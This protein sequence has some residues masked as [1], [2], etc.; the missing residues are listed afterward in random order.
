[1]KV[2]TEEVNY[3][4]KIHHNSIIGYKQCL[5]NFAKNFENAANLK[6][7]VPIFLDTNVLLRYYS[8][9]FAAREKLYEFIKENKKRI[10][11]SAQV[12]Y[13]FIKNREEVIQRFFEQ[14]TNKIPRDFKTD[15]VNK[16]NSF[17]DVHKI[18]LQDYPFVE[19]DIAKHQKELDELLQ[20]LNDTV[21]H[22]RKEHVDLILKDKFLNLLSECSLYESLINEEIEIV[23]KDF[24]ILKKNVTP[25]NL[26]SLMNKT[27]ST[28]PGLG[29][30]KLKPDN[31]YGDYIIYHEI[32]KY[33]ITQKTD[34]I[35]L[36]FDTTKG[37]WMTKSKSPHLHYI[38][39]IHANTGQ[40]LY[41]LD[42]DRTLGETLNTN[43]ESLVEFEKSSTL[44][45][46]LTLENI[47]TFVDRHPIFQNRKPAILNNDLLNELYLAGYNSIEEIMIDL[48]LG[49]KILEVYEKDRNVSFNKLG[50]LRIVLRI[51]NPK[52]THNFS[53][54][55]AIEI[56]EDAKQRLKKYRKIL[57]L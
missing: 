49:S 15:V 31:P 1:M 47:K 54:G 13:E 5:E 21:E 12:Q 8:I 43:V 36:T 23:K 19:T 38:Q 55:K 35:F 3:R 46:D 44:E 33:M 17:L 53:G 18:V 24:D 56:S 2:I 9:S 10:I 34:I 37:D 22:K 45:N 11:I 30:I 52:Y 26:E 42:A 20:K 16:M 29:D 25:E 4:S 7:D 41:I 50:V 32:L 27:D 57:E 14:V 48:N 28:F 6:Y 40:I 39:N 51:V